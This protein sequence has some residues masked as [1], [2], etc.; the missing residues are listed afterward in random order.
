MDTPVAPGIMIGRGTVTSVLASRSATRVPIAVGAEQ[1]AVRPSLYPR[2][3]VRAFQSGPQPLLPS[4]Q[5]RR[6]LG[7]EVFCFENRADFDFGVAAKGRALQPVDR[8]VDRV[9][10]PDPE[11][12]D[13]LLCFS[14]RSVD[15]GLLTAREFYPL[16]FRAGV[17]AL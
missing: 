15:N 14:E 9:H 8:L 4:P 10:L 5:L 7:A 11:T 1:A 12:C 6:E 2:P 3:L 16:A 13:Q 17:K